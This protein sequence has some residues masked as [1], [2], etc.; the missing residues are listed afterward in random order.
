VTTVA[1][2]RRALAAAFRAAGLETPELDAKLLVAAALDMA[3]AILPREADRVVGAAAQERLDD[4]RARRLAREPVSRILGRK[5]FWSLRLVI[6]P[7]VLDPRPETETVVEAALAVADRGQPLR[8]A[9]LGTGS[10]ALLLAL[11][12]ELPNTFG[13][14]TDRST[15]ALAVARGNASRLGLR[16]R[17]GFV[18]CDFGA[19]LRGGFDLVVANPPYIASAAI[20]TLDPEVRG[21]DPRLALDGGSDGLA[22]YRAIA[23][24]LPRL[25][26]PGGTAVLEVGLGQGRGVADLLQNVGLTVAPSRLDLAGIPRAVSAQKM[27]P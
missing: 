26:A 21:H 25:L 20:A 7:D 27:A 2:A 19:A 14:G 8:I 17:C 22:A 16:L 10:G 1:G 5:E 3:P 9:D 15:A 6:T 18:A 11:L 4:W 12:H 13:V 23:A 24:D